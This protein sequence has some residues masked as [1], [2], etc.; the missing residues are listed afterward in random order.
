MGTLRSCTRQDWQETEIRLDDTTHIMWIHEKMGSKLGFD[1]PPTH[2]PDSK[3][4]ERWERLDLGLGEIDNG[5][6]FDLTI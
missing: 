4:R 3:R 1:Y 6:K 2:Y 5:Q